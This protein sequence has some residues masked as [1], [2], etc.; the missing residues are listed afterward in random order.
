M[1]HNSLYFTHY[2][3]DSGLPINPVDVILQ[4]Q[5]GYMWFGSD[6]GLCRYDGYSFLSFKHDPDDRHSISNESV[7]AM[8]ES[9][10]GSLWIGVADGLNRYDSATGEFQH[11]SMPVGAN[12][13]DERVYSICEAADGTLWVGGN[14][15]ITRFQPKTGDMEI[16]YL[17]KDARPNEKWQVR[18]ICEFNGYIYFI[19]YPG[20]VRLDP[21]TL[22]T[23]L[24]QSTPY[25]YSE[26]HAFRNNF[27]NPVIL[28]LFSSHDGYLW[29]GTWHGG[30]T[31]F[32]PAG[33]TFLTYPYSYHGEDDLI[34]QSVQ[35][36]A[37]DDNCWLWLATETGLYRFQ[38]DSGS[39]IHDDYS[40]ARPHGLSSNMIRAVYRDRAGGMWIASDN[41]LSRYDESLNYFQ[42]LSRE[43]DPSRSLDANPVYSMC[44]DGDGAIW[45]GTYLG[46]L[47]R[48]D[49][50]SGDVSHFRY[51][52][53]DPNTISEDTV[54]ALCFDQ[55]DTLWIGCWKQGLCSLNIRTRAIR[56]YPFI[57]NEV[58]AKVSDK[59]SGN[60]VRAIQVMDDGRVWIGTEQGYINVLDPKTGLFTNRSDELLTALDGKHYALF[61]MEK[62][63]RGR[64]WMGTGGY[65]DVGY[66]IYLY[67]PETDSISHLTV[68][69][70]PEDAYPY[71]VSDIHEDRRGDFWFATSHGL[72]VLDRDLNHKRFLSPR[73]GFWGREFASVAE[74]ADGTI[75]TG[76]RRFGLSRFDPQRGDVRNF[77]EKE[78]LRD[79]RFLCESALTARDGTLYFGGLG[80]VTIIN[81]NQVTK[82]RYAPPVVIQ[83]VDV[84]DRTLSPIQVFS[85]SVPRF[86]YWQNRFEFRFSALSFTRPE[87]NQYAWRL[88][89][90][91]N[92][93][94]NA[95][96]RRF[97]RYT[98]LPPGSY[99]FEVK[100]ANNDGVWN[101]VPA[102]WP[103]VIRSPFWES[104]W[105]RIASA[106]AIA[107]SV[108]LFY[109]IRVHAIQTRN[110]ELERT[111]AERTQSLR[112]ERDHSRNILRKSPAIIFGFSPSGQ[113]SF[114][115]PAGERYL[116]LRM[117]AA[118]RSYWWDHF[119]FDAGREKLM[120]L[121]REVI[122]HDVV[123]QELN[124]A[125]DTGETRTVIWSFIRHADDV[126]GI[127]EIIAFGNDVT[128]Q[129]EKEILKISSREQRKIGR[130]IHD[131][132][133]QS[134]TGIY[135]MCESV[136]LDRSRPSEE[137]E[138][139]LAR[140]KDQ[141][142]KV[143]VQ[144]RNLSRSLYLH[145]L[146]N[147]GLADALK[148]LC[149]NVQSLFGVQC[150]FSSH[151]V[152]DSLD[153][154]VKTQLYRIAQEALSNAVKHSES[155]WV[156]VMLEGNGTQVSVT[157]RDA[158]RGFD[159][160]RLHSAGM[161]LGI[162]EYRARLIHAKLDVTS[163]PGE[164]ATVRCSL[165][166]N[167][168]KGKKTSI[169]SAS[170]YE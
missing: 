134:L 31:R 12:S 1:R 106:A 169:A 93:W 141:I 146:E 164:G 45:F 69:D 128:E 102:S 62:D 17:D 21:K 143:T 58:E 121:H 39:I 78:G 118:I 64:L 140:I 156:E 6:Y 133:C 47:N 65:S 11:F 29:L 137:N 51:S 89:G 105:F 77:G 88:V 144:S 34:N 40:E 136:S 149:I 100:G 25:E 46:G 18:S 32:D 165:T 123:D 125:L 81:P 150:R 80:G 162:M 107:S 85:D 119:P 95:G 14:A 42:F 99:R 148:A 155:E 50:I 66:G 98:H 138:D 15:M 168:A 170:A 167:F 163:R 38:L 157:V 108:V 22:K 127:Y 94:Y 111:V 35:S 120:R 5:Q 104:V 27:L 87:A 160:A 33:E 79:P 86:F 83:G 36:I 54:T 91:E 139:L 68:E 67:D 129:F 48:Y 130:E 75:W 101:E 147:S 28:S 103:F 142:Q 24:Y 10:D 59:L 113:I 4:D 13:E 82:N 20:I 132:L 49:P 117:D 41:T 74:S 109:L 166:T 161:G 26:N 57:D 53:D 158:G 124:V 2:D 131:S 116:G 153:M 70:K 154:N 112:L 159:P 110:R 92:D 72:Y 115:N 152:N 96:T 90:L 19:K 9:R 84:N 126:G 56:R 43:N 16:A 61:C 73:D 37:E 122:R 135:F 76:T 44:E 52:P 151:L 63:S 114:I 97:A 3:Y 7:S 30:L 145:E 55:H 8:I 60:V 71:V 23:N